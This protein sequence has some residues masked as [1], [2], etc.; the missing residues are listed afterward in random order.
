MLNYDKYEYRIKGIESN[1]LICEENPL[2]Q[3]PLNETEIQGKT[4]VSLISPGTE[5]A[6][7]KNAS[8]QFKFP[9]SLGYACVFEIE[10]IGSKVTTLNIGDRV[11]CSGNHKSKQ[12]APENGVVKLPLNLDPKIAVFARLMGVS[13]ST[14]TTTNARP[15]QAVVV[16]GLGLVGHLAAQ[17]FSSC[18]YQVFGIDPSEEK[19]QLAEK[20]GLK[21]IYKDFYYVKENYKGKISLVVEC[22]GHEDAIND[23][24]QVVRKGGEVVMVG[25][26]WSKRSSLP[27]FDLLSLVFHNYV[28][29]RSGWEWEVPKQNQDFIE[30]SLQNNYAGAIRWLVENKIK[31]QDLAETRSP[32]NP[33]QI[34]DDIINQKIKGL[35]CLINWQ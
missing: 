26:P 13:M 23:A 15:P 2:N 3:S 17:I 25:V 24:C 18:G 32:E 11:F 10:E 5:L 8:G 9:M 20:V 1:K 33:Q 14:L 27:A 21:N 4:I 29:L 35:S 28:N 34:Y 31:V 12:V 22:S 7:L 19:R 30:G 6:V 16:T